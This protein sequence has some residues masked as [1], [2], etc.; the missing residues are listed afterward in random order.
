[1]QVVFVSNYGPHQIGDKVE[2][3]VEVARELIKKGI[4]KEYKG[5]VG[6]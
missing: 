5:T 6:K 4:C 1:V 3:P 2:I